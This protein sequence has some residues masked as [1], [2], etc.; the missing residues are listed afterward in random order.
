MKTRDI[1]LQELGGILES[2]CCLVIFADRSSYTS[3]IYDEKSE[4]GWRMCDWGVQTCAGNR[5]ID[6]VDTPLEILWQWVRFLPDLFSGL[7]W[8][9]APVFFGGTIA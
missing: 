9:D 4:E 2:E 3:L 8:L 5:F 1:P 7:R 6:I